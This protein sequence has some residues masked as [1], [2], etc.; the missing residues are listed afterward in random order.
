MRLFFVFVLSLLL[1]TAIALAGIDAAALDPAEIVD[2]A[3]PLDCEAI[4]ASAI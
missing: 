4:A 1:S 3:S 2:T